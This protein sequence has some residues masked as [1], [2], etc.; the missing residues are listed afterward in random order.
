[1][2]AIRVFVLLGQAKVND[3]DVVL[4]LLVTANKE[5]VWLNVAMNDPLLVHFLYATNLVSQA[6]N[7]LVNHQILLLCLITYHLRGDM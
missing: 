1:M 3:V 7:K 5:I 4:C 2:L 6:K